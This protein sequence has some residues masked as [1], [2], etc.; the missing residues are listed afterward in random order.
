[1]SL[2]ESLKVLRSVRGDAVVVTAMGIAREWMALGSHPLD[3]VYVPSSMGQASALGMGIALAQ[4]DRK[5]IACNGDGSTLMNLGSLVTITAAA[6]KNLTLLVFNNGVYE[7]T[8]GQSTPGAAR[9][10]EDGRDVDFAAMA[11]ACGFS[12]LLS[13]DDLDT[14]Q[15]EAGRV[16]DEPGPTFAQIK[17]SPMGDAGVLKSPGPGSER[18][19]AFAAE[20][21]RE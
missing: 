8:G 14:W 9:S 10:R 11:K 12:S 4:P 20:L 21:Q 6:P 5:V 15:R 16:I 18:A 17:V 13:F 7:V 19:Q 1:M 2:V 3:F